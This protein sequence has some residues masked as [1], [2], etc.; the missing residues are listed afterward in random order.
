MANKIK[1]NFSFKHYREILNLLKK[2]NYKFSFFSELPTKIKKRVYLRHDVD[3]SLEKALQIALIEHQQGIH[4]TYFVRFSSPFYNVFDPIYS[5]IIKKIIG[6]GHQTGLHFEGDI[7]GTKNLTK[8]IIEKEVLC[9]LKILKNYFNIKPV[10]SFHRPSNF[11]FNREFKNFTNTYKSIFFQ[12]I[13]YLS[14]SKGNWREGCVCKLLRSSSFPQNL[15]IL[16][17]PIWWGKEER[18]PNKH[19]KYYLKEKFQ[20]L[21]KSLSKNISV[22]RRKF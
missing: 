13:K 6:L 20:Y 18:R 11:V 14:D 22:Y 9:Q 19:L 8:D 17:H 4:S 10:V 15:Q 16:T 2:L 12:E 21:D 1:C 7:Y 3:L 5:K